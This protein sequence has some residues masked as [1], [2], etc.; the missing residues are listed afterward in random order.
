MQEKI[1]S[2]LSGTHCQQQNLFR[3]GSCPC[4][5]GRFLFANVQHGNRRACRQGQ[6]YCSILLMD[7]CLHIETPGSLL[8]YAKPYPLSCR[9]GADVCLRITVLQEN[10]PQRKTDQQRL[11]P[12]HRT[13]PVSFSTTLQWRTAGWR[14]GRKTYCHAECLGVFLS[15]IPD[16]FQLF[17][18][19]L[20]LGFFLPYFSIFFL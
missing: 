18:L 6:Y 20:N 3:F 10:H 17:G 11:W 12:D 15:L 9:R 16:T 19:V 7:C 2:R 8:C 14:F 13:K 5:N 4:G 1:S